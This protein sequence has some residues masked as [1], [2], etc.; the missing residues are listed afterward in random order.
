MKKSLARDAMHHCLTENEITLF[1]NTASEQGSVYMNLYTFL[2][3]TGLRIG[4]A[5]AITP[6]DV[7]EGTVMIGVGAAFRAYIG[8]LSIVEGG[9]L[10]KMG[11]GGWKML[12]KGSSILKEICWYI[13]HSFI[14][15][16]YFILIKW[17]QLSGKKCFEL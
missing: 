17:R 15:M 4:E 13:K 3:N 16:G 14:L 1:M 6:A 9:V 11:L 2:L 8:E 10:Q 7:K 5:G 12:R